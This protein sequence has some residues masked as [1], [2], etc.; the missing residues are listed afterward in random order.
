MPARRQCLRQVHYDEDHPRHREAQDRP[1]HLWRLDD[2]RPANR[3]ARQARHRAGARVASPVPAHDGAREPGDGRLHAVGYD[4]HRSRHGTGLF[5]LPAHQGTAQANGRNLVGRRAAD[6][7]HGA[8]PDGA[9]EAPVHGRALDGP[10]ASLRRAGVRHYRGDQQAGHL[11]LHGG[12]E[13]Q[14]GALDCR[15]RLCPPDWRG[16]AAGLGPELTRQ[17]DGAAGLSRGDEDVIDRA[18][19]AARFARGHRRLWG[20]C[21]QGA[22]AKRHRAVRRH[23][24]LHRLCRR[25]HARRSCA[26]LARIPRADEAGGFPSQRHAGQSRRRADGDLRHAVRR[27]GRRQQRAKLCA[28]YDSGS[29]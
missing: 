24:W 3:R 18:A 19:L 2:Q 22:H 4:R 16:G 8:R 13:R 14:Y 7:G 28:G 23:R 11:D 17:Q 1:C 10:L 20:N 21:R 9:A 25:A 5:A 29:G 6:G 15:L 27:K 26:H 12:A